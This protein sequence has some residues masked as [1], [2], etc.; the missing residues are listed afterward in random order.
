MPT[1]FLGSL[2]FAV[3]EMPESPTCWGYSAATPNKFGSP[4][5]LSRQFPENQINRA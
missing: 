4:D 5:C 1:I 2:G 3:A